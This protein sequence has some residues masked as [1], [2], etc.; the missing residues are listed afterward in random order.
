MLNIAHQA[1][2]PS[3]Y[4]ATAAPWQ[5]GAGL[6]GRVDCDVCVIGGGLAGVS[7]ALELAGRGLRVALLEGSQIG[8]GAAGRNGG[9]VIAAYAC[10]MESI[11]QQ[12]GD[13]AA[14][15]LWHMSREAIEIVAQHVVQHGIACD[16]T[17]GYCRVALKPAQL[18]E[19]AAWQ[20]QAADRYGYTQYALWD[21][22]ALAATLASERY[23]GALFDPLAGHLHPLNY[24]L[25]LA[26][27]ARN[28]GVQ[29]YENSP[30]SLFSHGQ[31]PVVRTQHGEVH[32]QQLVLACNAF[33]GALN[34]ALNHRIMSVTTLVIATAPL[35]EARARGLIANNM[36]VCDSDSA[37]DYCRL[38]ADG[39]LLFGGKINHAGRTPHDLVDVMRR[40]MLCVFP[41]LADMA[42]DYAWGGYVDVTL[43]R[44]PDFGRAAANV[45]YAQGFSGQGVAIAGLAG[46]L[47]AEAI[48]GD[49]SRLVLFEQ[50]QHHPFPGGT[51][52]HT[53]AQVLG[54]SWYRLQDHW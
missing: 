31:Q 34:P 21:K 51:P 50:R 7:T 37:L 35:G 14:Q 18:D 17:R 13:D 23:C 26:Q 3:Y 44:T 48:T 1:H 10:E 8:F 4:A 2:A 20:Q 28:A 40:D 49:A 39:R 36:A 52:L 32:C 43:N 33:V 15:T 16:W 54:M 38:S 6:R 22:P 41:Q 27:A 45:Y 12:L 24:L 53:P 5:A 25:G 47:L 19:L 9:Q 46:R 42:I 11:R 29:I 30:V